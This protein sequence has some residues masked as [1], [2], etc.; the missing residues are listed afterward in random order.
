MQLLKL[1]ML[2]VGDVAV[3]KI[4][5]NNNIEEGTNELAKEEEKSDLK[6]I[7]LSVTEVV[8]EVCPDSLYNIGK[9]FKQVEVSATAIFENTPNEF[10]SKDDFESVEKVLQGKN[11]LRENI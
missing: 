3:H 10:L 9:N 5:E 8:D 4:K 7:S 1:Q 11:H 6:Q 2:Q